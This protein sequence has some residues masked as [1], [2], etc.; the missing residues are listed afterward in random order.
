MRSLRNA[1]RTADSNA[2]HRIYADFGDS[3]HFGMTANPWATG[4]ADTL[5]MNWYPVRISKGYVPDAVKWFPKVR[6][7]L[8]KITPG[9]KLWVMAQTFGATSFDQRMPSAAEL[10]RQ[11]VEAIRYADVDGLAFHTW[12]NSLY[13]SVLGTSSTLQT[14]LA[15]II[16]RT[17]AGTFVVP[18]P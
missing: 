17:R 7:T 16:T 14:R 18:T 4:I 2:A 8:D 11:V 1:F 13:Q 10:E 6:Q 15:S 5:I 3:P 12:R 9:A